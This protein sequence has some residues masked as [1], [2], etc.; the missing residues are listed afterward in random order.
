MFPK[1]LVCITK[2]IPA[3]PTTAEQHMVLETRPADTQEDADNLLIERRNYQRSQNVT[4]NSFGP[5][6]VTVQGAIYILD[7]KD[8]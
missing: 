7:P 4:T 6:I 3:T 2:T 1:F 5:G 8:Q